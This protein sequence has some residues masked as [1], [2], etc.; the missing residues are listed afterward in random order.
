MGSVMRIDLNC[1]LLSTSWSSCFPFGPG[2]SP[3]KKQG[4]TPS[5]PRGGGEVVGGVGPL[6]DAQLMY[7]PGYAQRSKKCEK[8]HLC[9]NGTVTHK[10]IVGGAEWGQGNS[11]H[12]LVSQ[13]GSARQRRAWSGV[14]LVEQ[15]LGDIEEIA[16]VLIVRLLTDWVP[17]I[18]A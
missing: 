4:P 6:K 10:T 15:G 17:K 11:F 18:Q 3:A 1:L 14:P 5:T 2:V 8:H 12:R 7:V 13:E 9:L 16:H